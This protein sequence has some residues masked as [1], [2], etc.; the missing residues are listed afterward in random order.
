MS[1]GCPLQYHDN[2]CEH[3]IFLICMPSEPTLLGGHNQQGA[4]SLAA[5]LCCRLTQRWEASLWLSGKQMY[6]GGYVN[7]EDAARAYDLAALA[8]KGPSVPTN[9]AAFDYEGNLS[10]IRGSSRVPF[11]PHLPCT[12][13]F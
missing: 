9:F 2:V 13:R 6:L 12:N 3:L 11:T 5:G 1:L 8:C 10:E 4:V 7:E